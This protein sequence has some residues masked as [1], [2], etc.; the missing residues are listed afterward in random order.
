LPRSF[1]HDAESNRKFRKSLI[2]LIFV[3]RFVDMFVEGAA[4]QH[5]AMNWPM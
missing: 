2:M 3:K 4:R 5:I 1:S